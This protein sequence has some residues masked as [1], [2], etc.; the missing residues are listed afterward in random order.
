[1]KDEKIPL[2]IYSSFIQINSHG[3]LKK[4]REQKR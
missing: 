1:M 3:K 4:K 2:A